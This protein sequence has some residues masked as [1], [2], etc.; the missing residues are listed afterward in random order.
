M[1][2]L[3]AEVFV[4]DNYSEDGTV[5]YLQPK[6]SFARF[7]QNEKNLGFAKA[8]NIALELC[9]GEYVLFLNPILY[10]GKYFKRLHMLFF[11][12]HTD[13]GCYRS[14]DA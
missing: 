9:K 10:S 5:E 4:V 7:I 6:Y 1:V 12:T 8:N 2:G 13:A 3:Q 14:A 11:Q